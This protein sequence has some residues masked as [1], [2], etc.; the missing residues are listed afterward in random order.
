[1]LDLP[2]YLSHVNEVVYLH[3]T[4]VH[5]IHLT[6]TN[7][8]TYCCTTQVRRVSLNLELH[9]GNPL[10]LRRLVREGGVESPAASLVFTS[11]GTSGM[12]V[13][14]HHAGALREGTLSTRSNEY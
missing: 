14:K 4:L 3:S 9:R 6:S 1:M 7:D 5:Y 8:N 2:I 11:T 10:A 12:C 13:G